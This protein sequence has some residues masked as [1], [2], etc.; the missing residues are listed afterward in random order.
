[1]AW[2]LAA[3]AA[4]LLLGV[5]V[6]LAAADVCTAQG[7]WGAVQYACEG[8]AQKS[9]EPWW[10]RSTTQAIVAF[11]GLGGSSAAG[12]YAIYR[13]RERRK[14][15]TAAIRAIETTYAETKAT[16]EIG[17]PRLVA[18][19]Q[20][21]RARHQAGKLDDGNFLDLDKRVTDHIVRLRVLDLDR[22]FLGLPPALMA[23]VRRLVGDGHVSAEDVDLVE[24][25]ATAFRVPEPRLS[26]L[27]SLVRSWCGEDVAPEGGA[28]LPPHKLL[29]R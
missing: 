14:A 1:M 3:A 25:H 4:V 18:L 5:A 24:R 28:P 10:A 21:L 6:P 2:R 29:V 19:R 15:L 17:I 23:E 7:P 22:R 13:V 9:A 26:E 27:V 20:D 11:V 8:T 16:P 12:G